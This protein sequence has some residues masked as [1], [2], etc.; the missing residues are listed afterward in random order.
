[1]S[2]EE[3]SFAKPSCVSDRW[4]FWHRVV[5]RLRSIWR[6]LRITRFASRLFG[7][8]YSRSRDS[9]EIDITYDCNLL[10]HNCNRSA[11]QAPEKLHIPL[12]SVR[13]FVTESIDCGK[14]WKRIRVLGGEPTLHPQFLDIVKELLRYHARHQTCV[15]EIVTN[16]YG[17]IVQSQLARL[18][19]AIRVENSRKT[20]PVQLEF[21]PFNL[22]PVDDP[23]YRHADYTNGCSIMRDCGM[24]LTP[25]GYYPCAISGGIDRIAEMGLGRSILPDDSD[26][27]RDVLSVSCSLCGRFK[28]G[29]Y[30]PKNLRPKLPGQ[31]VSPSWK[32]LYAEWELRKGA[33]RQSHEPCEEPE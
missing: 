19:A 28:D 26:D 7:P 15:I 2:I 6:S 23:R 8:Q 14:R 31:P 17:P 32:R 16:G 4:L 12:D 18:P 9:I 1:M 33:V 22:A 13:S 5:Y 11:S 20:G 29:H 21:A 3:H 10:C 27:M 24:G 25:S 30:V